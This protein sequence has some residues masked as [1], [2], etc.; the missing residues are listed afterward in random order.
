MS[1]VFISYSRKDAELTRQ[2]H[3]ALSEIKRDVWVDWEDIPPTAD[4]LREIYENIEKTAT[5]VFVISPNSVASPICNLEVAHAVELNKRLVPIVYQDVKPE[6]IPSLVDESQLD[7]TTRAALAGRDLMELVQKNWGPISR[8][9]WLFFRDDTEFEKNFPKLIAGI[10]T[11]FDHVNAHTRWLIRAL[12]WKNNNKNQSFLL[13]GTALRDAENWLSGSGGKEPTP[14]ELHT[15]Y[16]FASRRRENRRQRTL[17]TAV[18]AALAIALALAVFGLVQSQLAQT[19]LTTAEARGT[20]VANQVVIAANNAETAVA[21]AQIADNNALTATIAQGLAQIEADNAATQAAVAQ[22]AA[23]AESNARATSVV[24]EQN[25]VN[26]AITATIAQGLA[27]IEADNAATQAAAAQIAATAESNARAT[28]V[29]NEQNAVNN[30]ITAT[31]AQGRAQ[32]EADNAATQAAAAQ[33]AATAE[34]NARATSVVNEQN[35]VNNAITATLAQGEAL[36]QAETAVAAVATS[37]ANANLAANNAATAEANAQIARD[38]AVTATIAQGQAQIEADNAATQAAVAQIAATAESNARATSVVNEQRAVDNAATATIA[39]GEAEDAAVRALAAQAT[40]EQRANETQ[41][42]A[43]TVAI[44]QL[45][46]LGNPDLALALALE[47]SKVDP[48]SWVAQ[49]RLLNVAFAP[50]TRFIF[51]A[52]HTGPI[53]DLAYSPDGQYIAS[54]SLDGTIILW[55][56]QTGQLIRRFDGHDA[57]VNSVAFNNDGTLL[58]SASD[59]KSLIVWNLDGGQ[60]RRIRRINSLNQDLNREATDAVFRQDGNTIVSGWSDGD[61]IIFQRNGGIRLP[62]VG[63]VNSPVTSLDLSPDRPGQFFLVTSSTS[64]EVWDTQA[65]ARRQIYLGRGGAGAYSPDGEYILISAASPDN[66]NPDGHDLILREIPS[67]IERGRYEGHGQPVTDVVYLPGEPTRALSASEDGTIILWD[68]PNESITHRYYGHNAPI[69]AIAVSPDGKFFVSADSNFQIRLW[70]TEPGGFIGNFPP[71]DKNSTL[72]G[73]QYSPDHATIL[74]A[75]GDKSLGFWDVTSGSES[76]RRFYHNDLITGF[77]YSPDGQYVLSADESGTVSLWNTRTY[78]RVFPDSN[79]S[80]SGGR[81]V[82]A[83]SPDGLTFVTGNNEGWLRLFDTQNGAVINRHAPDHGPV[84]GLMYFGG[85]SRLLTVHPDRLV[86]RDTLTA[87]VIRSLPSAWELSQAI[88]SPDERYLLTATDS[89]VILWDFRQQNGAPTPFGGD[90]ET[91]TGAITSLA[92]SP[93]GNAVL[94]SSED[95]SVRL[96]DTATGRLLYT[97]TYG[98]HIPHGVLFAP[99]GETFAATYDDAIV[100]FKSGTRQALLDWVNNNR[101]VRQ[102]TCAERERYTIKPLCL[103]GFVP[104]LTPTGTLLPTLTATITLTPSPTFTP[105]QPPLPIGRIIS[106]GKVNIRDGNYPNAA[107]LG[108]LDNGNMVFILGDPAETPGWV[109]I[110]TQAGLEG[111][112]IR[113]PVE[114]LGTDISL[115]TLPPGG[116][117]ATPTPT[118]TALPRVTLVSESGGNINLRNGPGEGYD[119]VARVP[120]GTTAVLLEEPFDYIWTR[121]RLADEREGWV[122]RPL[123]QK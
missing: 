91:H 69:T 4:W 34:S 73:L 11:D 58:V 102:L 45:I 37:D 17:F 5:F 88:F 84:T 24:N 105:T 53:T 43:L 40:A 67:A 61:V 87:D 12:E 41:S 13:T 65:A 39:Q 6:D 96:W 94:S 99:N 42:L 56:A 109:H 52:G 80:A 92:F 111:W 68:I 3:V 119:L 121:V 90:G 74:A 75:Y 89:S 97:Y 31:I 72:Y 104:S 55:D 54:S 32:I 2:L 14:A 123:V 29:V 81:A 78:E 106:D 63:V 48:N 86:I 27:Q 70:E 51:D 15:E 8:H 25:A 85:G 49:N 112:V 122:Y 9:N 113:Q 46:N 103:D 22:I 10:D 101:F 30:A 95:G 33:I 26:N 108:Q 18:L 120:S 83:Y 21:N 114:L 47:A 44:E 115:A 38:N 117:T 35:A 23:T 59:D 107:L 16:I 110:R 118:P 20:E 77:A 66:F 71:A 50:G 64:V 1:D 19:A 60:V 36:I 82:V 98:D 100:F 116:R 28:S 57:G 76:I 62:L 93:D 7:A 79:F